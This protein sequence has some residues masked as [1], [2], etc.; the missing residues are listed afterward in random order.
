MRIALTILLVLIVAAGIYATAAYWDWLDATRLAGP[1]IIGL[2]FL[3]VGSFG[4][5]LD[6]NQ[7]VSK[8]ASPLEILRHFAIRLG[9]ILGVIIGF[10]GGAWL[11]LILVRLVFA[12][13]L[14]DWVVATIFLVAFTWFVAGVIKFL[15]RDY[16]R[17]A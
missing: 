14:P 7:G 9:S 6:L 1:A 13:W 10:A 5:Y 2:I 12:R 17:E 15:S 3:A 8:N 16:D 11:V 4:V